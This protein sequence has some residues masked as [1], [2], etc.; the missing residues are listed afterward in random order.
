V[1][2]AGVAL[3]AAILT[4]PNLAPLVLPLAILAWRI[5]R[6]HDTSPYRSIAVAIGAF[7]AAAFV[8]VLNQRLYG[9]IFRSGYGSV[10]EL[11][12]L[13]NIPANI[14]VYTYWLFRTE[15]PLV[16]VGAAA[17]F[18]LRRRPVA[19]VVA[20][21][22]LF[23]AVVWLPYLLYMQFHDW[24]V[25]RFLLPSYPFMF[26]LMLAAIHGSLEPRRAARRAAVVLVTIVVAG[27]HAM[28]V[29]EHDVMTL[30]N[31]EQRFAV[32]GE[33]VRTHLPSNA[34]ILSMLHSGS[35]R[36]YS[37]HVTA[38]FD[39]LAPDMLDQAVRDLYAL[40]RP[41]FLVLDEGEVTEFR[42][43]FGKASRWG[44]LDWDAVQALSG[45]RVYIYDVAK[46]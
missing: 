3:I 21:S 39:L 8:A 44:R 6:T 27:W 23:A 43:R 46:P 34:V 29:R 12:A 24:G 4:R 37:G 22:T 20:C 14:S 40:N 9:S 16:L 38:R 17:I 26:A 1:T 18:M 11:Y 25:L 42:D 28:Y 35:I 31:G 2:F 10:Q 32:A 5:D 41:P 13:A 33:Y 15:T 19:P 36:F 7:V 30:A 45:G